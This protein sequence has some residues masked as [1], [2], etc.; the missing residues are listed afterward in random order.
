MTLIIFS[1]GHRTAAVAQLKKVRTASEVAWAVMNY[2]KHSML[3]GELGTHSPTN[4]ML[5]YSTELRIVADQFALEM[6]F[7]QAN[8]ETNASIAMWQQWMKGNCQPNYRQVHSPK[9]SWDR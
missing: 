4:E 8:L 5:S 2:T 7:P 1:P 6:G 9:S 3:V